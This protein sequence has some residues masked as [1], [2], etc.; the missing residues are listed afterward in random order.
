M[1]HTYIEERQIAER[2]VMG[3]LPPEEAARFEEHYLSCQ[4]CLDRLELSESMERGFKRA[5]GQDAVRVAATRQIAVLAWLSRLSRSRQMGFLLTIFL[6]VLLVPGLLSYR[7]IAE[8]NQELT[9]TR[10]A[11]EREK[12][13]STAGSRTAAEVEKLRT[14]L[15]AS[16]RDLSREREIAAKATEQL[17]QARQP[18]G[19]VP[20]LFLNS[21]RGAEGDPTVRL[22]LPKTPGWIVL[23]PEID[24]PQEPYRAILRDAQGRELWRG[25]D[26]RLNE[27]GTLSLTLPSTLLAPGDYTLVVE[28]AA[29]G[30]RPPAVRFTFRVLPAA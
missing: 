22:R 28:G 13:R 14:E 9:E 23:A 21:E 17:A 19:N 12:E 27:M 7:E 30:A 26:L 25:G 8:R 29:S 15:D 16:R 3:K 20:I 24:P 4:E 11:L 2:Y 18:Q 1:D 6:A 5:A 10:T